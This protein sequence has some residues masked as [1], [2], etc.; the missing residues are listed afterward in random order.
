LTYCATARAGHGISRIMSRHGHLSN[1]GA[2][3]FVETFLHNEL[4]HI[5]GAH[6]SGECNTPQLA[7]ADLDTM[8][9]RAGATHTQVTI[10]S[11]TI[12]CDTLELGE[13]SKKT[14]SPEKTVA[15]TAIPN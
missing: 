5:F 4:H 13:K 15:T 14:T 9:E 3:E 1:E 7:R 8:L 12:P 2:A 11:Q 6:L 10:T